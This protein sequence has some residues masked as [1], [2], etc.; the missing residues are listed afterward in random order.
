MAAFAP[1]STLKTT[2]KRRGGPYFTNF[3]D[4]SETFVI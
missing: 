3:S 4:S 2:P 1:F